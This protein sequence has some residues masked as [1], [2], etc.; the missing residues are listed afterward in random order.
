MVDDL[1]RPEPDEEQVQSRAELTADEKEAGSDDPLDQARLI[2]EDSE[3][4]KVDRDAAP[5]SFVEHRRSDDTVEP[6]E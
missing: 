5:G 2:L 1:T 6:L 4:R 3:E